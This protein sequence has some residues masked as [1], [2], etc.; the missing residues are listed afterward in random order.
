MV[1]PLIP[2]RAE[3]IKKPIHLLYVP[4]IFCNMGCQYCYLGELTEERPD[5]RLAVTTLQTTLAKLLEAGYLPFN[6]SFHGGEVTTLP[7]KT[8]RA[9]FDIAQQHY[10]DYGSTIQGMGFKLNPIHV[11]TNLLNFA[12]H[13][14]LMQDYQV[15]I[16]ASIDLPLKLHEKYRVDKKGA[17]TLGRI[18]QNLRLLAQYPH[19]KKLSC[20][21]TREHLQHL[22][23]FIRDIHYLHTDI[24]LDMNRFNIMF[25]FDSL[26]NGEKFTDRED[27]LTMLTQEE[28]VRFYH[29]LNKAF[30]GTALEP[31]LRQEWFSEFTP[32]YCCSAVNCGNKFFLLQYD[33]SVYS[34]PRGQSSPAYYYGNVFKDEV[35]TII[36]NGWQVIERNENSMTMDAG[37]LQCEYLTYCN[38]GCTFVRSETGLRKSYTCQLQKAIYRDNPERYVPM[39]AEHLAYHAKHLQLRNNT[40]SIQHYYPH[41]EH[42]ITPELSAP[43]NS[44]RHIVQRDPVLTELFGNRLF[45]LECNGIR[46]ALESPILRNTRE[47]EYCDANSQVVLG[48]HKETFGIACD[49]PVNNHVILM[50]LR[51][52]PVTYGDEGRSK[53]EHIV[54]YA[55]YSQSLMAVSVL[56]D[57]YYRFD[58]HHFLK[59]HAGFYRPQVRNNLFVTTKTLREYHYNKHRKNAFYHVQAINL[60]FSNFEFYWKE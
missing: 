58:L 8:L 59:S 2:I 36:Q 19:R 11:K 6:L 18:E 10:A 40:H 38:V 28:Q 5:D 48:V 47:I 52:T 23:D 49:E 45:Y 14:A 20:V 22:D 32:D 7:T 12:K 41:K 42:Y 33:G 30:K 25:S 39:S 37:C 16:S 44:L 29:A 60:P 1:A 53:Q 3:G 9:L 55:L 43:E 15:S 50:L 26:K 17:S 51:N 27:G 24:G 57:D 34:C 54:D 31:G 46:Y 13:Y 21:V 35:E 4:T 56:E